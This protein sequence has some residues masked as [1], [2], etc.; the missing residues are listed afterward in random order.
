MAATRNPRVRL[1]HIR[2][3]IDEVTR[4]I[5]GASFD[6]YDRTLWDVVSVHLP[7]LRPIVIRMLTDMP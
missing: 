4:A 5:Q 2:D 1:L 7:L 3:E 6:Q